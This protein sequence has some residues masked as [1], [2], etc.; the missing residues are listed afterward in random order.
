MR[1]IINDKRGYAQ[2]VGGLV[3]IFVVILLGTYIYWTV[4]GSVK[5]GSTEGAAIMLNV[6]STAQTVMSLAPIVGIIAIASLMIGI[7]TRFGQGGT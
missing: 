7:V 5:S 2:L 4:V 1:K 3:A 6:N